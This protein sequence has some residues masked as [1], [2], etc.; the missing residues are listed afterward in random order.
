MKFLKGLSSFSVKRALSGTLVH[1]SD[2]ITTK[3]PVSNS[4]KVVYCVCYVI[5]LL[6]L[7]VSI[8]IGILGVFFDYL[9]LNYIR[10]V[11]GCLSF[12]IRRSKAVTMNLILSSFACFS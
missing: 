2:R 3:I 10:N 12:D 11:S 6:R 1:S 9:I 8:S 4:L 7:Q 5:Y